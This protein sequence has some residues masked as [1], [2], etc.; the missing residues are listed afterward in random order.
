MFIHHHHH[1]NF[2]GEIFQYFFI[3][4]NIPVLAEDA[5]DA[6]D[7]EVLLS[8]SLISPKIKKKILEKFRK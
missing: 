8:S 4:L 3:Y 7:A 6:E 1:S 2:V 5:D